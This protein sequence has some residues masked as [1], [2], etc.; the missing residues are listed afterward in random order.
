MQAVVSLK[1]RG[2]DEVHVL[3]QFKNSKAGENL[4]PANRS[5]QRAS[6]V[7]EKH[8]LEVRTED[9]HAH[10]NHSEKKTFKQRGTLEARKPS[11]PPGLRRVCL[12]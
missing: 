4:E 10:S 8:L 1:A 3:C 6:A 11:L 5:R 2:L 9:T 12:P 7:E